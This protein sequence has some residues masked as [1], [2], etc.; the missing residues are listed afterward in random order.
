MN[1]Y[2]AYER[3][4]YESTPLPDS[5]NIIISPSR[6]PFLRYSRISRNPH[7]PSLD[8]RS[9]LFTQTEDLFPD[10]ILDNLP[11]QLFLV[12]VPFQ[13]LPKTRQSNALVVGLT[14]NQT[15]RLL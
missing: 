1:N 15:P 2:S 7:P 14:Q 6:E 13:H 12:G 3:S 4:I 10:E 5:L 11:N 8:P 9:D